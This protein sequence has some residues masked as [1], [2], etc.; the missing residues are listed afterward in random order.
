MGYQ[1]KRYALI[2]GLGVNKVRVQAYLPD[3]YKAVWEGKTDWHWSYTTSSWARFENIVDD[4]V[5]IEGR[6]TEGGGFGLDGYIRP[7]LGSGMMQCHEI[8][9]SHPI[10]EEILV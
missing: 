4:V 10:M 3:N 7:R 1:P 9:L 8:D 6:D 5:L 2:R